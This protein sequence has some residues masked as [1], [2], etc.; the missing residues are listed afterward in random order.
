[1]DW[2]ILYCI[3]LRHTRTPPPTLE[4]N[5]GQYHCNCAR[6]ISMA[7]DATYLLYIPIRDMP[8]HSVWLSVSFPWLS[9]VNF[10]VSLFR[11]GRVFRVCFHLTMVR[12]LSKYFAYSGLSTCH[13]FDEYQDLLY[14]S[15]ESAYLHFGW[16]VSVGFSMELVSS[17]IVSWSSALRC[18]SASNSFSHPC[19]FWFIFIATDKLHLQCHTCLFCALL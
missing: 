17:K 5:Y 12:W 11:C 19:H 15:G 6:K 3:H 2:K 16:H 14:L 10:A 8:M 18:G 1:M 4:W 7:Y 13:M 9:L